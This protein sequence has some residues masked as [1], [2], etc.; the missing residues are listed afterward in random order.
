MKGNHKLT[1]ILAGM[2]FMFAPLLEFA[3]LG[4]AK[5]AAYGTALS[6]MYTVYNA[7]IVIGMKLFFDK[8]IEEHKE[9]KP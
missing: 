4:E 5:I 1:V 6:I 9:Q 8:N 3:F 2:G 7:G